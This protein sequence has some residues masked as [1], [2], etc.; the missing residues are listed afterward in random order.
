MLMYDVDILFFLPQLRHVLRVNTNVKNG[1]RVLMVRVGHLIIMGEV[2]L[3]T[4]Q[5]VALR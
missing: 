1:H 4:R 2:V 3:N 5:P